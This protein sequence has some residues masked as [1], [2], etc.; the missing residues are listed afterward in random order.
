MAPNPSGTRTAPPPAPKLVAVG[1]SAHDTK[2]ALE[3]KFK[4]LIKQYG[5]EEG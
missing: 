3:T 4:N 2:V 5:L 1:R